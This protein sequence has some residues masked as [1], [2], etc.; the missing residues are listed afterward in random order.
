MPRK[1]STA[2]Q[3]F[4]AHAANIQRN[5][6]RLQ[7]L[8]DEGFRVAPTDIHWGHVGDLNEYDALLTRITDMAFREGEY[9][10]ENVA[11]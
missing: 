3:A 8:A 4:Q 5:L 11:R 10:P 1:T 9:A 2:P 7:K 6:K